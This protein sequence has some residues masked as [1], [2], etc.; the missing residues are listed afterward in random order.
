MG[1][2]LLKLAMTEVA[3]RF[4][5]IG[6]RAALANENINDVQLYLANTGPANNHHHALKSGA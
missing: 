1:N 4:V 2:K 6:A 5:G 3:Q